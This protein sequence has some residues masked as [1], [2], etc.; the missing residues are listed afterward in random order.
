MQLYNCKATKKTQEGSM[1]LLWYDLHRN[2]NLVLYLDMGI[3]IIEL[4]CSV[5]VSMCSS[6][7]L[8]C[9]TIVI[10]LNCLDC[11]ISVCGLCK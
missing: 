9:I 8:M 5:S 11:V 7:E 1:A 3:L 2:D 4:L 10:I 6:S